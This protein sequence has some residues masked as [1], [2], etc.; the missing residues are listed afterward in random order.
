MPYGANPGGGSS[1]QQSSS[2]AYVS[3]TD[4]SKYMD[5]VLKN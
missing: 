5:S 1:A 4:P 2:Q 3:G